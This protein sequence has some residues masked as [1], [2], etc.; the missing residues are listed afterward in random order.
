[1]DAVTIEQV[2]DNPA[3][4][5]HTITAL[6]AE[7]QDLHEQ[8]QAQINA[9]A[10]AAT[11]QHAT[12]SKPP[13]LQPPA[14]YD[15]TRNTRLIDDYLYDVK[16]HIHN[17][18]LQF[19]RE[20]TKIRFAAS[21]LKGLARTWFRTLD[22]H[23]PPWQTYEEFTQELKQNF[24]ELDPEEYWR[25]RW[26]NL[27]QRSS[28]TQYLA[29]FRTIEAHLSLTEEDKYHQFKRGLRSNVLDQLALQPRPETLDDLIKIANQVDQRL[30]EHARSKPV[31]RPTVNNVQRRP[32]GNG[33]PQ[34]NRPQVPFRNS[35]GYQRSAPRVTYPNNQPMM[36][37]KWPSSVPVEDRMQ[38]DAVQR[39]P[40]TDAEKDYRRRNNLCLYC[41]NSGHAYQDC[42]LKRN[43]PQPQNNKPKN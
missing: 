25:K 22:E 16:Q 7:V 11:I 32:F 38:L 26:E 30:F 14:S 9:P 21:Y 13:K 19:T 29:D 1:M 31:N 33:N 3:A 41:G 6:Q 5:Q 40:L 35:Q 28:I 15:G 12:F 4:A 2:Q 42:P 34:A 10:P 8:I 18:P 27:Q 39:G 37:T 23:N 43:R 36:P 20:E 17:D 24:A